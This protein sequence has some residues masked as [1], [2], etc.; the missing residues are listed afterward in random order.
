ML[1]SVHGG[2]KNYLKNETDKAGNQRSEQDS[3]RHATV[4]RHGDEAKKKN[5][6][7]KATTATAKPTML[8]SAFI[9]ASLVCCVSICL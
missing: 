1:C 7:I 3:Q 6:M 8:F 9:F 2:G 4:S 5:R